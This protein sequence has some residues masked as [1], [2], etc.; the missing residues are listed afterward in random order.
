MTKVTNQSGLTTNNLILHT[1]ELS[2]RTTV[3]V[4]ASSSTIADSANEFV[5]AGFEVGDRVI[6]RFASPTNPNNGYATIDTVAAG[7]ITV[8]NHTGTLTDQSAGEACAISRLKKTFQFVEADGLDFED[9]VAGLALTSEL[10]QLWD[11]GTYDV[12]PFPFEELRPDAETIVFVEGWEPHDQ[13]TYDAIRDTAV[14]ILDGETGALS[15]DYM[16]VKSAAFVGGTG[17]AYYWQEDPDSNPS[18]T[19]TDFVT[20]GYVNQLVLIR[21]VGNSIDRRTFFTCKIAEAGRTVV[22]YDLVTAEN[23]AALTAKPYNLLLGDAID[24]KL[25]DA[26]GT[27]LVNDTAI[28]SNTP[29][30][31]ITYTR[32]DPDVQRSIE[33]TNYNFDAII[34]RTGATAQQVHQKLNWLVRQKSTDIDSGSGTLLGGHSPALS[35][36]IGESVTYQ[37][38]TDGLPDGEKNTSTF[39]DSSG[40]GRAFEVVAAFAFE[41]VV[42]TNFTGSAPF[43][44]FQQSVFG[45]ANAPVM[46]DGDGSD[47][48]GTV[49][50]N[51]TA[52]FS[53]K[54]N[55][56]NQNGHPAGT[57]IPILVS[58]G[59]GDTNTL[60]RVYGPFSVGNNVTQSF[61]IELTETTSYRAAA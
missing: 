40:T 24:P 15:R 56:F 60:P 16:N 29:Y 58:V 3:G 44:A 25:A 61:R 36:F 13:N 45:V 7:T 48:A 1:V 5:T 21:D 35:T 51:Q 18:A 50:G 17:I 46:D 22:V 34:A 30:T 33:G 57:D 23:T 28:A 14:R 53:I 43:K 52:D 11:D 47:V 59:G 20:N 31:N 6:I 37:G 27:P 12:Y 41:F 55:S 42:P 10:Q 26:G 32:H 4:T 38:F 19:I 54:Y 39:I 2:Q 9:G 8:S 49:T